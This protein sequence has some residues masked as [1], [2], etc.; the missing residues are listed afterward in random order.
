[1][2]RLF[3]SLGIVVLFGGGLLSSGPPARAQQPD[4]AAVSL[5]GSAAAPGPAGTRTGP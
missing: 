3:T 5:A 2:K 4:A 1:M